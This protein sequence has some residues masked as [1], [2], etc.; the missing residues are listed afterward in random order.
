MKTLELKFLNEEKRVVTLT[1]DDP[2]E[3]ADPQTISDVMD[4]MINE[5]VFF[6]NGGDLVEKHSA[7]I[8]ERQVEDIAI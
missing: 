4:Q 3:P 2:V 6:S 5:Q 7:R 8:V 1:L